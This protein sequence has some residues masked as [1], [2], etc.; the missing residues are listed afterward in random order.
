VR[1][2]L[3][4]RIDRLIRG[5]WAVVWLLA[6]LATVRVAVAVAASISAGSSTE[7]WLSLAEVALVAAAAV[8]AAAVERRIGR[9]GRAGK[10][11]RL[12][13]PTRWPALDEALASYVIR[14]G[15]Q[16]PTVAMTED[17]GVDAELVFIG[18]DW[19]GDTARAVRGPLD[20]RPGDQ[21]M[22]AFTR[23]MLGAFNTEELLAV[24]AQLVAR[25]SVSRGLTKAMDNGVREA[26]SR[27]LL[28]T[29]NH[30][31]LLSAV[32][33]SY[34]KRPTPP[35]GLGQVRFA[36]ADIRARKVT[37]KGRRSRWETGDRIGELRGHLGPAGL[38]VPEPLHDFDT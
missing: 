37:T 21:P 29:H 26:D 18:P 23:G 36:D 38:D 31:A 20:A 4:D 30:V 6:V 10:A 25:A 24:V 2:P 28:L 1:E 27:A 5:R 11:A 14:T 8:F 19:D 15:I 13:P 9:S 35:P 7:L 32:E 33:K 17:A 12:T 22:I 16:A 34:G 3:Y